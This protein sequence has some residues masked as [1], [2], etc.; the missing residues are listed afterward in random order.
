MGTG[1]WQV[2]DLLSKVAGREFY[3][4]T[5]PGLGIGRVGRGR[6]YSA[7]L[8]ALRDGKNEEGSQHSSESETNEII[9]FRFERIQNPTPIWKELKMETKIRR[10][11]SASLDWRQFIE[12]TQRTGEALSAKNGD[13]IP[14]ITKAA[15]MASV[16]LEKE[17][18][19]HDISIVMMCLSLAKV[20]EDRMNIDLYRDVILTS[21]HTAQLSK[22]LSGSFSDLRVMSDLANQMATNEA[23]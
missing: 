18:T 23:A 20:S 6:E 7:Y 13:P 4:R 8:Q 3:I 16:M 19:A 17:V 10:N 9:N 12:N 21:A 2:H 1:T 11:D 5:R 15:L 22:P 14:A